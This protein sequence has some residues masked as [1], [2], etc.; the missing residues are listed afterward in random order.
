MNHRLI[1]A[2]LACILLFLTSACASQPS[3]TGPPPLPT[4][5]PAS[6]STALLMYHGHTNRIMSLAWSPD[7]KE[8]AS[9]S[10]DGTVQVWDA[11]T[12][13]T[14][15]TY[16]GHTGFVGTVAWSP[17]GKDI[18]SGGLTRQCRSGTPPPAIKLLPS[19]FPTRLVR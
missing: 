11:S 12:G 9:G 10:A 15:L 14:L 1:A 4:D 18:A 16:R 3:V 7:G 8:I 5:Q 6:S 2:S 13:K 19:L 17:D